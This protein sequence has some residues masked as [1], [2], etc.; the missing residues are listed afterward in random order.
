MSGSAP[1]VGSSLTAASSIND[2]RTQAQLLLG[3][4]LGQI[5]LTPL[6]IYTFLDT[7]PATL[8]FLAWQFDILAPWWQLLAGSDSQLQLIQQ[9][10]ALHRFKGTPYA[11]QTIASNLGF[12][13]IEI[14]EGQASWGGSSWPPSE[15]WAVFRVI[16]VK[17]DIQLADPQPTSWDA[18][19]NVD[20]LIDVDEL[21]QASS[22]VGVPVSAADETQLV[23]AIDFFAP[24]RCWLDSLWF[25]EMPIA[26]PALTVFDF[27]TL[28]AGGNVVERP[29][30]ISDLVTA[31]AWS[32][33]D[34]K[35]TAPLY[36][37]H[38]Y[39]AGITYGAGE[40]AVV[41]SGIVID[42]QPT[43]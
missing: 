19:T 5:D 3:Q 18:V 34:T 4:R 29:L 14:E 31:P 43:E 11:I 16:V 33:A 36:S 24:A 32:L 28:T 23:D 2:V 30:T 42:G 6:L 25:Q 12:A 22:I 39:H 26:E 37:A 8:P 9:A 27:L 35:T 38:F 21:D 41:D 7:P 17:A 15:G 40:P 13:L 1:S 20:L 10:I